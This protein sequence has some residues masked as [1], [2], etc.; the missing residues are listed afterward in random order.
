MP[1]SIRRFFGR[2]PRE[3]SEPGEAALGG[4]AR[5]RCSRPLRESERRACT[6]LGQARN[7]QRRIPHV[8]ADEPPLV[9]RIVTLACDYGR[10]GYRR[11]MG[12]LRLEGTFVNHK[13][14]ERIWKEEGL[15][16]PKKQPK[17]RRLWL[18]G[19]S[20]IRLRPQHRDH[21]WSFRIVM[22][23][24]SEGRALRMLTKS[25]RALPGVSR[26]RRCWEAQKRGRTR[27]TRASSCVGASR[28]T[29][30]ATLVCEFTA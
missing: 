13:R 26:H 12:L 23:R 2:P 15:K 24:T 25:G 16:V 9:D 28:S 27:A 30:A 19:G 14:G 29:S 17:R 6:V 1:R 20:C 5:S 3:T 4:G 11:V 7:T 10:Y 8:A 18:N 21:V 22:D